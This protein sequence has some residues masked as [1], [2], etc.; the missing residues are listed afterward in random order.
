MNLKHDRDLTVPL[1]EYLPFDCRFLTVLLRRV[2]VFLRRVVVFLR[3]DATRALRFAVRFLEAKTFRPTAPVLET[4]LPVLGL[5]I[6]CVV[7]LA[8]MCCLILQKKNLK[9]L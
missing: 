2:V 4:I 6:L 7:L 1:P 5:R 9:S 3:V 8:G